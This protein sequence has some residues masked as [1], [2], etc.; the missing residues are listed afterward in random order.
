MTWIDSVY[1]STV[2]FDGMWYLG[3]TGEFFDNGHKKQRSGIPQCKFSTGT[4]LQYE[5]EQT[6][7]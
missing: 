3:W 7:C 5:N 6:S 4:S 1:V 2:H